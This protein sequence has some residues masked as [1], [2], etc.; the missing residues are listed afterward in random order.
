MKHKIFTVLVAAAA[1]LPL[2]A[3]Q[4]TINPYQYRI[5]KEV[6]AR[7][8][9]VVSAHPLAS[10]AGLLVMQKGGNA[11][12]AAIATQLALAV[13]YPNAGNL[14]GGGFM[15]ARLANGKTIS[16]DYRETAPAKAHRD[17]YLDAQGNVDGDKSVN[18]HLSSGVPG[19]VAGLFETLP[20]AKL[21]FRTLIQ[22]AI[23]L[24]VKGFTISQREAA[25]LNGLQQDLK[26][27][28][29]QSNALMRDKPWQ[30]GDTLFQPELGATLL[31]IRDEGAKG[32][33]EGKTA[34]LIV[35]EMQRGG[36]LITPD[37]LKSYRA[38]WRTPHRFMYKGHEVVSMPLPSSGGIL[39]HQMLKMV[40]NK[41]LPSYGFLSPMATHLMVEA[42]RR[43]YADRAEFMGDPDHVAVPEKQLTSEA[44]IKMRMQDYVAGVAGKSSQ[45]KPGVVR[46][47][48]EETTHI[49]IIDDRGNAVAVTTTLNNSYGSKTFVGGAG[50]L[51]N[52]EMD[53]FSAKPGVPNMYGAVGGQ[54]NAIAPG[55]RMLSSMTP[56]LVLKGGKPFLV[57]GT[58]GGTTIPT[59]VYQTIID[60]IDFKLPTAKAVNGPKFHHQWLPDEIATEPSFP[61]STRKRLEQMGYNLKQ[62]GAIGRTEV[63]RVLP[64]GSFE[65]VADGRGDDSAAGY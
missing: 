48:S 12:D 24:A 29:T 34:A 30:A 8:G 2:A 56:T 63:I 54:A 15:V 20:Y 45:V 49:S 44:Y 40:E 17:M 41:P 51:L 14:G 25:S 1:S 42:E 27:Y 61:E 26:K 22:P 7:K 23:D 50:F 53:D 13:V 60:I 11:F 35:A 28:N 46:K 5:Q 39:L 65:A 43:A 47:E 9:A 55:K 6:S 18:G 16:L 19:T 21:P 4:T 37:D 57:V 64:N 32:F 33:Y 10:Q 59:S 52:D 58:P 62:R 31:R 38:R 36:G 3:Q